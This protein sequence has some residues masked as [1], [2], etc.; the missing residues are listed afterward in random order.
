VREPDGHQGTATEMWAASGGEV[1]YIGEWHT[2]PE[3]V[4]SPSGID[5]REW[6][7]LIAKQGRNVPLVAAIVGTS[8]LYVALLGIRH[9]ESLLETT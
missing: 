3:N 8:S 5:Q 1:A 2:H 9:T 4:P 6:R 7:R